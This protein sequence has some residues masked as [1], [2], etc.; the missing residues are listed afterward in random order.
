MEKLKLSLLQKWEIPQKYSFV[1]SSAVLSDGRVLILT[2]E[3]DDSDKYCVLVLSSSGLKEVEVCDCSDDRRNY[4]V[5]FRFG[6]GFGI[7]KK[8]RRFNTIP[9]IFHHRKS[10]RSRMRLRM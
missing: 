1:H 2:N 5:L 9:V 4:P 3:T 10:Y 7:I 6:E 8:D